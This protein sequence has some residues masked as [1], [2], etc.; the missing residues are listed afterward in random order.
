MLLPEAHRE[1]L[2]ATQDG[3][4]TPGGY[5]FVERQR[6]QPFGQRRQRHTALQAGEVNAEAR[7][8]SDSEH[9][10]PVGR[11]ADVEAVRVRELFGVAMSCAQER[12]D[13]CTLGDRAAG[14]L[15]FSGRLPTK[16]LTWAVVP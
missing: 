15:D 4:R 12:T 5:R 8:D 16:D 11:A 1:R 9:Q 3:A 2:E 13:K 14:E 7:V 6:R 10:V